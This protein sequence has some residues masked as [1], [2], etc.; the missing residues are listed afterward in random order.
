M[1]EMSNF[2]PK[3]INALRHEEV[4][5]CARYIGMLRT[6]HVARISTCFN[7]E[8]RD[9]DKNLM[10]CASNR[11]VFID[12]KPDNMLKQIKE[13]RIKNTDGDEYTRNTYTRPETPRQ[14]GNFCS[15]KQAAARI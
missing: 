1:H 11:G 3:D 10:V 14:T 15:R 7:I 12:Q 6:K 4:E 5:A 9:V 2:E 13:T 8:D